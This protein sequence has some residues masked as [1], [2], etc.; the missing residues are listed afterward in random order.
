ML[1]CM[2]SFKVLIQFMAF[3]PLLAIQ[4]D[5]GMFITL[6]LFNSKQKSGQFSQ[7]ND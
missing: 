6:V 1:T 4:P 2:Q 3:L 5:K 7:Y